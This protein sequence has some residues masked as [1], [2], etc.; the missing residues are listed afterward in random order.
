VP[1][2]Y[3]PWLANEQARKGRSHSRDEPGL[4]VSVQV[5][6]AVEMADDCLQRWYCMHCEDCVPSS[7]RYIQRLHVRHGRRPYLGSLGNFNH[8][9]RFLHSVLASTCT[10][11]QIVGQ[12][13]QKPFEKLPSNRTVERWRSKAK[14]QRRHLPQTTRRQT[15]RRSK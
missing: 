11:S 1:L 15:G 12:R 14:E 7:D 4:S 2:S 5:R 8:Y 9:C 6:G 10:T 3:H 13:K